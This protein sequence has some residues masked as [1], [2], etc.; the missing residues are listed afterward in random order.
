MTRRVLQCGSRRLPLDR[1]RIMAVINV[2]PDSFSDGGRYF[3]MD[4][5]AL[6][7]GAEALVADGAD[8]LDIG[9]ESTRP[10]APPVSEDEECARVLPALEALL[11]LDAVISIDTS[12]PGV[13]RRALELGCHMINDVT[14][15][16]APG[17]LEALAATDAA[18]VLMHMQ[19]EPRTMQDDPRYA[20][21][22]LEVRDF[23]ESRVAACAAV[24]IGTERLCVDP[25]FGF[26]KSL[27]H[28]LT[29]LREL[30]IF[31]NMP[32][33]LLVGLSRKSTLGRL[34]GRGVE[35]REAAS[36]AAALLAAERGAD[37]VRVHDVAATADALKVLE[38]VRQIREDGG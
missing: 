33:A 34:T 13:A 3:S 20:D 19:G 38:A 10:G 1:T 21:V 32:V 22:V 18:L 25:G 35:A 29:L 28:N 4:P 14:A 6:R 7:A 15:A 9:G 2:T 12:K 37:V 11:D 30:S 36:V 16:A 24:G 27:T 31:Q 26:G 5:G 23:L 17:M 8:I